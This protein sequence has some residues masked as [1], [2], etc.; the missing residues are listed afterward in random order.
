MPYIKRNPDGEIIS[1]VQ[2]S[3]EDHSE[4]VKATSKELVDFLSGRHHVGQSKSALAES[5]KEIARVTEDLIHLLIHKN[6][7]LF[8]DLPEAVQ[9]KLIIRE[10]L[11]SSLNNKNNNFLLDDDGI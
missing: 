6:I 8:T 4:Y 1:L 11:R 2:E 10:K 7:I 3:N 5:D 9:D